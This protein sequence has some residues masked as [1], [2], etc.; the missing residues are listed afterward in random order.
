MDTERFSDSKAVTAIDAG[1]A[2]VVGTLTG[3]EIDTAGYRSLTIPLA[4]D[5]TAGSITAVGFTECDTS[6]GTFTAVDDSNVLYYPDDL[7]VGADGTRI[8]GCIAKKRYVK[9]TIVADNVGIE[10]TSAVGLLQASVTKPMVKEAS[11]IADADVSSPGDTADAA[12]T[13]PKR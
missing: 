10:I 4:I 12:S 11:V 6:G 5:W 1:T 8:V 3:N 2:T 7:P 13:P 9:L